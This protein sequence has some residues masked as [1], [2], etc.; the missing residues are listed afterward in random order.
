MLPSINL[1]QAVGLLSFVI[2]I[3]C[4]YQKDDKHLKIGMVILNFNNA[5]HYAMMGAITACV[6][7]ILAVVRTGVS[8]RSSSKIAAYFFILVAIV[9]GTYLAD[10]WVDYLPILGSCI[11]TY[12]LFC[13]SGI[14]MRIG[15]IFGALCWLANNIIIGSIGTTLLEL[16]LL[17]V[18]MTTI[19]RLYRGNL[20]K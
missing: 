15:F 12:S 20:V 19:F 4:F 1:A 8:L 10:N 16:T 6:G 3:V 11:G 13:L 7:A 14:K 17:I 2:G 5:I 9:W 18:N